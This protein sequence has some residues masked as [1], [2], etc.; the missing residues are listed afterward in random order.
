MNPPETMTL[1]QAAEALQLPKATVMILCRRGTLPARK[2]GR[3][4]RILRSALPALFARQ[5]P[6]QP[7]AASK[8][9]P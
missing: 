2:L 6:A 9:P 7:P 4:W 3:T 8:G 1:D 5:E